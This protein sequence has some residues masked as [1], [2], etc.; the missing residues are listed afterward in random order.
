MKFYGNG[1]VWGGDKRL[2]KFING[3][4]ETE[5]KTVIDKLFDLGY[6]C[7]P[8]EDPCETCPTETP[9][10]RCVVCE[11]P[12]EIIKTTPKPKKKGAKK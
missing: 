4:L 11:L 5:D 12:T 2:C 3:E 8:F 6:A 1:V 9:E 10:Q 7:E